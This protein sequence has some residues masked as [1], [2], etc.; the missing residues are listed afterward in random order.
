VQGWSEVERGQPLFESILVFENYPESKSNAAPEEKLGV[1]SVRF[2]EL[3]N[4]PLAVAVGPGQE[5]SFIVVYDER[6]F[7]A[8]MIERML[9]HLQTLLQSIVA[10][11]EQ[12]I[13]DLSFLT[14]DERH[15]LLVDWNAAGEDAAYLTLHQIFEEHAGRIPNA[16]A[17]SFQGERISYADLNSRSNRLAHALRE[18]GVEPNDKVAIMLDNSPEQIVALLGILKSGCAFVCLD[19]NYPPNRLRQILQE[20]SPPCL[21]TDAVCMTAHR[22][23][24]EEYRRESGCRIVSM[25]K[26]DGRDEPADSFVT[27]IEPDSYPANNPE[28]LSDPEA[29]AYVVYTSGSTGTPKG[30]MQSH[31]SFAQF[32]DWQNRYCDLR[33]SKRIAQ[34]ASITYDASYCEIFG[35]L[36]AGATLCMETTTVRHDPA[37]LVDWLRNEKISV[38]I[39]VPSFGRQVWQALEAEEAR[40]AAQALPD[41][42]VL[43]LAGEALPVD[44]A[45]AWLERFPKRPALVNL[46]GPTESVLAT[47]YGVEKVEPLQ[48]SIPVGR[49][50]DGR[51]I[52]IL[53]EAGRLCP[54]GVKGEIYIRSR[55]LTQ[56]Y[57]KRPE[58]TRKAFVQ[59]PL[60]DEYPDRVYRT[61]DLGRWLPDGN[62]EFFG[63]IDNQ[64]KVRGMR[65]ELEDIEAA[66]RR[67]ELVSECVVGVRPFAGGDERLVAYVVAGEEVRAGVLRSYLKE[68]VPDYMVPAR[69]LFLETMPRT[70]S[71]KIDRNALP[72]PDAQQPEPGEDFVAPRTDVEITVATIWQTLLGVERVG[73]DDNFFELGGHSLLATQVVNRL[74]EACSVNLPLRS[75]FEHPTVAGLAASIEKLREEAQPQADKIADLINQIKYLSEDQ[76]EALL[77]QKKRAPGT[78]DSPGKVNS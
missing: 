17:I 16:V 12:R 14:E 23:L 66:L 67:H 7:D 8:G 53:D 64:V 60:H 54:V 36:C 76:V 9:R 40:G 5:L 71:G 24:L 32:L 28:V 47:Y 35:A 18:T 63:R 65:V 27:S 51:Q 52:L 1:N 59:N 58:E 42:E 33:E 56:G 4:Y 61:G 78:P 21:I 22:T 72:A 20:V 41:L 30:I 11:P 37:A 29:T 31:R 2:F 43:G 44:L 3:T 57:Y 39:V 50:I 74:R 77:L 46:Y 62:I 49:A 38:L 70:P 6:R 19:A 73:A 13:R 55:Y 25:V 69:F 45:R 26:P 48:T 34:W 68:S 15:Q 75:V 10:R